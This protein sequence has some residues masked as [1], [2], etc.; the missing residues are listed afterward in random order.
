MTK[1][2]VKGMGRRIGAAKC[3]SQIVSHIESVPFE[4][5]KWLLTQLHI[6]HIVSRFNEA[7]RPLRHNKHAGLAS[8]L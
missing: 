7:D 2:L 8:F 5:D 4:S 6:R 3:Y 1:G